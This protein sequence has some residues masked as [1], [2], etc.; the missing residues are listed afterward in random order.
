MTI[1]VPLSGKKTVAREPRVTLRDDCRTLL[2]WGRG[3]GQS[4][5]RDPSTP[6]RCSMNRRCAF[7]LLAALLLAL[8]AAAAPRPISSAASPPAWFAEVVSQM[9]ALFLPAGLRGD[10]PRSERRAPGGRLTPTCDSGGAMDPDGHHC[11]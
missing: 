4:K 3:A 6:E 2:V 5:S 11:Q 10:R 8:P 9:G 7:S 1:G